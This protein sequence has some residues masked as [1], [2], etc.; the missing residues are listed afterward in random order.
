MLANLIYNV[1]TKKAES[2]FVS[3]SSQGKNQALAYTY[4]IVYSDY[5]TNTKVVVWYDS[6]SMN[7]ISFFLLHLSGLHFFF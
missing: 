2:R 7:F 5:N 4:I 3:L 6:N 1:P